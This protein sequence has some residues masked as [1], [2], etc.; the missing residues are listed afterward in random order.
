MS[1][2]VPVQPPEVERLIQKLP[3]KTSPLDHYTTIPVHFWS[4]IR[5]NSQS[6]SRI[7]QMLPFLPVYFHDRWSLPSSPLHWKRLA[8][9]NRL[10]KTFVLLAT[11]L[12]YQ[13][14]S[15]GWRSSDW[16]NTS[17]HHP[18]WIICNQLITKTI[19]RRRLCA[20]FSTGIEA[21]DG[22]HITAVII[23]LDISACSIWR[24]R[25]PNKKGD[26][27]STTPCLDNP[28]C[29]L[30]LSLETEFGLVALYTRHS[31]IWS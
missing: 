3:L 13:N 4:N 11:C 7:W 1:S 6:S 30:Y 14:C 18:T 25:S 10:R 12:Q 21:S 5:W 26:V 20:R 15:S 22:G 24:R 28:I 8:S 27:G 9:T 23:S 29:L 19:R 2:F 17:V 16:N 31:F